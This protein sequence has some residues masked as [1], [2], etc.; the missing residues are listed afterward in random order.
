M[1]EKKSV[2]GSDDSLGAENDPEI[3]SQIKNCKHLTLVRTLL[4]FHRGWRGSRAVLRSC[5]KVE[6]SENEAG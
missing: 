6:Q 2:K 1:V 4:T 5:S 3:L